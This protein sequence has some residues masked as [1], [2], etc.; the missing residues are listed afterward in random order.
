MK[1]TF[2]LFLFLL[3]STIHFAAYSQMVT[4]NINFDNYISPTD[5]DLQNHF[6]STFSA[7]VLTP[8]T[9]NGITGGCVV[10]PDTNIW[11]N[12]N[13]TYCSKYKGDT[14]TTYVTSICFKFD[15]TEINPTRFDRAMAIWLSPSADWNHYLIATVE[16]SKLIS[17]ITY[18]WINPTSP[19]LPLLNGHWYKYVL[20]ANFAGGVSG[21]QVQVQVNVFEL[22]LTGLNSPVLIGSVSGTF[23][24]PV[25]IADSAIS[26]GITG[27]H[28]GGAQYLD[29][30]HFE[31]IKSPDSC[32]TA[33]LNNKPALAA[34]FNFNF[35]NNRLTI[36][37]AD[38]LKGDIAIMN[39]AGQKLLTGTLSPVVSEFDLS[40]LLDGV[41]LLAIHSPRKSFSEKFIV[42]R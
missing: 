27:S 26:V 30:F 35:K 40:D 18:G 9:N 42:L 5:N 15:S 37:N 19:V 13:A 24:D 31:G 4:E 11:G 21:D 6:Y 29:D 10:T 39:V 17:V 20:T 41:Y 14:A 38:N 25:L 33:G 1:N 28:W 16:H 8:I 36:F 32:F 7:F 22:G 23:N 12:D 34:D 3:A 2:T